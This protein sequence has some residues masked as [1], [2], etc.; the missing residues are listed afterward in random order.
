MP[1]RRPAA[2]PVRAQLRRPA[3]GI[4]R[5][6]PAGKAVDE[7]V[8]EV[9]KTLGTLDVAQL[10]KLQVVWFKKALYYHRE[11]ELVAQVE[12]LRMTNGEVYLE[13]KAMGTKDEGLLRALTGNVTIG[14][15]TCTFVEKGAV[16]L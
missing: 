6:R 7:E 14:V 11:I 16:E 5:R 3:A 4:L 9:R 13:C 12:S 10:S 2:A 8:P 1:L 15:W